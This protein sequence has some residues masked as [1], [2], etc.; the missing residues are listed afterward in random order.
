MSHSLVGEDSLSDRLFWSS[1]ANPWSVWTLVVAYPTLVIA[2][3]RRQRSLLFGTLA[4]VALN[5]LVF[6][7]PA[8]D[9]AWATRVVLGEKVWLDA[10]IRSSPLDALFV[11]L[12]APVHLGTIRSAIRRRP[13]RT[14]VGTVVSLL[15]MLLFFHRMV[16]LYER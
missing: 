8:D 3:Y 5:P 11:A 7:E 16:E 4:F 6:G 12:T 13:V 14:T 1:H 2:L 15:C 10:G 9:S